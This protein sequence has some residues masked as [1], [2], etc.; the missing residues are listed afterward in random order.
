VVV[1]ATIANG[2]SQGTAFTKDFTI[3]VKPAGTFVA[4]T[5]ISGVPAT[6]TVNTAL[7]LTGTVVP[8]N[9]TNQTIVW[10]V[11]DPGTTGAI[12]AGTQLTATAA[13]QAVVTAAITNG[14]G[15]GL[16]FTRDFTITA[17]GGSQIPGAAAVTVT[18]SGLLED[19]TSNFTGP[20]D[21]LSWKNNAAISFTV[22]GDFTSITWYMDGVQ[23]VGAIG[24]TLSLRAQN[25]AL[26]SHT[27]TAKVGKDGKTYT[28]RATFRIVE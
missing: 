11:K 20:T 5:G 4:V 18:F 16:A 7:T 27:V 10:T 1:T 3:I 26:G 22:T 15:Q 2:V 19:E 9:A 6:A 12:I 28:K 17:T 23:V 8:P 24:Q 25:Y 13:G 14:A 21:A